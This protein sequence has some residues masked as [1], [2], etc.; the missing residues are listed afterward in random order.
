MKISEKKLFGLFVLTLFLFL[1]V[2]AAA[3]SGYKRIS[4]QLAALKSGLASRKDC[5]PPL[6][7]SKHAALRK[8][9]ALDQIS[10]ADQGFILIIGDSIVEGM[11]LPSIAGIPV[12]NAGM[13]GGGILD[14]REL[15]AKIKSGTSPNGVLI[16]IGVNDA[17]RGGG[18]SPNYSAQWE[19]VMRDTISRAKA[20]AG[21]KVAV[22][23]V[24]PV[25]KGKPLG[26]QYFDPQKIDEINRIIRKVCAESKITL[27]DQSA[28]FIGLTGSGVE[29]TTDGVHL[30]NTG[31]RLMKSNIRKSIQ[32]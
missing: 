16:A 5:I 24:I 25:E 17:I 27:I 6:F 21:D 10:Q 23:T 12:I 8:H 4:V 30:N 9:F 15:I 11:N 7:A 18:A 20:L 13:G 22:S 1:S 31:Y 3:W 14:A 19:S 32:W 26:D 2:V 28:S 29:Y